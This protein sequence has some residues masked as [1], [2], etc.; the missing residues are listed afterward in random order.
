MPHNLRSGLSAGPVFCVLLLALFAV[1]PSG[2]AVAATGNPMPPEAPD[3]WRFTLAFPMLWAPDVDVKIRGDRREDISISFDD[4]LD[5]LDFGLMGE[6]YATRG[7]FGLAARFNYMD[8]RGDASREGG[9]TSTEVDMK[10]TAG[11]NDLLASWRVHDR[12]RLLTGIRHVHSKVRLD[13]RSSIG[14]TEIINERITVSDENSYDMLFG[15]SY[16]QWFGERWGLMINGDVGLFGD[17]DRNFSAEVRGIY[18]F[19]KLNNIWFGYRYL[20]IGNDTEEDGLSFE[21]NTTQHG[22]MVGWAFTF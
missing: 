20:R 16:D 2:P 11:V 3:Q 18:R 21:L 22:P 17:N 4:I 5:S 1:T 13:I 6:L 19:G 12:V 9:L 14:D 15:F 7:P 10:M 8:L